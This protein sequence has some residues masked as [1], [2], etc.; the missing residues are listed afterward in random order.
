VAFDTTE[1][2]AWWVLDYKLNA[3]PGDLESNRA[4]LAGYVAA[5]QALQPLDKVHGAFITAAG[6]LVPLSG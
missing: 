1:G 5:V 6:R 4:Q 3:A 2:R